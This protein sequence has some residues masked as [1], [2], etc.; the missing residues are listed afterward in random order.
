MRA[1]PCLEEMVRC[2]RRF[3]NPN[4]KRQ[5]Y[6]WLCAVYLARANL[7]LTEA[8]SADLPGAAVW[9]L[10][11]VDQLYTRMEPFD[12]PFLSWLPLQVYVDSAGFSARRSQDERVMLMQ[13]SSEIAI[14]LGFVTQIGQKAAASPP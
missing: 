6:P 12:G 10:W 11:T 13:A 14:P 1:P 4:A 8:A 9:V 5:T 3:A 2:D 7:T